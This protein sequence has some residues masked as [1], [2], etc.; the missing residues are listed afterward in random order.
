VQRGRLARAVRT[1]DADRLALADRQ[2]KAV[3][4]QER[5]ERPRNLLEREERRRPTPA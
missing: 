2:G 1:D 5:A 3:D 4:D